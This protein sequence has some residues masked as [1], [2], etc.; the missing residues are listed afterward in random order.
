MN[1]LPSFGKR[2]TPLLV[3]GQRVLGG[4]E[5]DNRTQTVP[6]KMDLSLQ[7]QRIFWV[8]VDSRAKPA[9]KRADTVRVEVVEVSV[10]ICLGEGNP[11]AEAEGFRA[12]VHG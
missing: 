7:K 9:E 11:H 5:V 3:H 1:D 6:P 2:D 4:L 8:L 12:V 10:V